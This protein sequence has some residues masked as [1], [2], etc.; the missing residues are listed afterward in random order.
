MMLRF[1]RLICGVQWIVAK[2]VI[3]DEQPQHVHAK[4]VDTAIEPESQHAIHR[5][6][7]IVITPVQIGLLGQER[8][9]VVLAR[10]FI[11][12]PRGTTHAA[13]PV[14]R[15]AAVGRGVMPQVPVA[16]RIVAR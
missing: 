9:I 12:L 5:A 11:P 16:L 15:W 6:A 3:L 1:T 2:L 10:M 7:Y 8:V 14:V 4:S 13:Q